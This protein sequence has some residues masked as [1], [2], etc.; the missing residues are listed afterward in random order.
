[1]AVMYT[2]L[3]DHSDVINGQGQQEWL[4]KWPLLLREIQKLQ[5]VQIGCR[6]FRAAHHYLG[7]QERWGSS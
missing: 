7:Y 2:G 3:N 1:M 4:V 6:N 5:K